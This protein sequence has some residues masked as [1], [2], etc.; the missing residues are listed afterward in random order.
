MSNSPPWAYSQTFHGCTAALS[1]MAS[2]RISVTA[3]I[4]RQ[5]QP[6]HVD[7]PF[8]AGLFASHPDALHHL[9]NPVVLPLR[10]RRGFPGLSRPIEESN[11]VLTV[12]PVLLA[13][14]V[15]HPAPALGAAPSVTLLR[16]SNCSS[17]LIF[18][19]FIAS[20]FGVTFS[21][22]AA[23]CFAPS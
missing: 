4:M 22:E 21:R 13:Q 16:R 15:Q 19:N 9:G 12:I 6:Q 11:R 20:E 8:A 18:L 14:L 23:I 1:S 7:Q 10:P 5:P 17:R 3:L 2:S